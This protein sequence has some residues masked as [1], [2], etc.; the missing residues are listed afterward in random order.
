MKRWIA[1]VA[2]LMLVPLM[3]MNPYPAQAVDFV[4]VT[5][6]IRCVN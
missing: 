4:D 5:V 2:L 3:G 1:V 6:R